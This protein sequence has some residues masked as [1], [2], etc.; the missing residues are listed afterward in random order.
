MTVTVYHTGHKTSKEICRA[1]TQ[2]MGLTLQDCANSRD[3]CLVNGDDVFFYGVTRGNMKIKKLATA[4]GRNYYLA[5]NGYVGRGQYDGY[6]RV[7]KNRFQSDGSGTPNYARL[8]RLNLDIKPW[9]KTGQYILLCVPPPEFCKIWGLDSGA[10]VRA[11][12]GRMRKHTKYSFLMSYKPDL[13]PRWGASMGTLD[14]Q[15]AGAWA[16]VTHNS[17]VALDALLAGVPAFCT[18]DTPAAWLGNTDLTQIDD[19]FYSP[20]RKDLF[21]TLA[22]QQWTLD[23]FRRGTPWMT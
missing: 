15:L 23:E 22:G 2:G 17:G 13:D 4:A 14:E 20:D 21:A 11:V 1:V 18:G 12:K 19:P 10:W 3:R 7:T 9:R 16:V 8:E 5:D 6:Y